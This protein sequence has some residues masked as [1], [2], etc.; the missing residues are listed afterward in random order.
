MSKTKTKTTP[1]FKNYEKLIA[2]IQDL[3][4]KISD[5]EDIIFRCE[6]VAASMDWLWNE[7]NT[8]D[9]CTVGFQNSMYLLLDTLRDTIKIK[10]E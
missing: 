7:H 9:R 10:E 5:Y 4:T 8:D 6:I 3:K 2:D 1:N